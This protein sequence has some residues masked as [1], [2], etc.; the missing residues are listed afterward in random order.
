MIEGGFTLEALLDALAE[1]VAI[2]VRGERAQDCGGGVGPRLLT[3]DQASSY[4]GR[5]KASVQHMV[6][7]GALPTVRADRRVFLDREDLGRWIEQNKR[8]GVV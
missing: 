1:R 7:Q 8:Q 3:V 4:L 2:K 5:S 6:S